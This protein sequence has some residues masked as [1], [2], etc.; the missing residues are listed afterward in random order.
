MLVQRSL[1]L[2]VKLY[3][4]I[5]DLKSTLQHSNLTFAEFRWLLQCYGIVASFYNSIGHQKRCESTYVRYVQ[6]VE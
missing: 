1:D 5:N 3:L 2:L 4:N 6:F